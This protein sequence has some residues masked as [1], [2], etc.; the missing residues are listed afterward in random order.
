MKF[1]LRKPVSLLLA[2]AALFLSVGVTACGGGTVDD[3]A[4]PEA[5]EEVEEGEEAEEAEE[6]E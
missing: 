2:T 4:E 3:A 6:A 5:T 1:A